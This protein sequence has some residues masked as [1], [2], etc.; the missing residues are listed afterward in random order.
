M[1]GDG[2]VYSGMQTKAGQQQLVEKNLVLK[3][4]PTYDVCTAVE[5]VSGWFTIGNGC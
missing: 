2:K 3:S 5:E 4:V 1:A